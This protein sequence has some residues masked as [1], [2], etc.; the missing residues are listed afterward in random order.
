MAVQHPVDDSTGSTS[1]RRRLW[2][3]FG[4]GVLVLLVVIVLVANAWASQ[5]A[6]SDDGVSMPSATSPSPSRTASPTPAPTKSPTPAP[7]VPS[8]PDPAAGIGVPST[9][10][11]PPQV[12]APVPLADPAAAVPGV[13]FSISELESVAGEA[14]GPGEVAGP[15][16]RFAVTVRNDTAVSVS[17]TSTVVNFYYGGEQSPATELA[18]PGGVPLPDAVSAGG[19][20]RGVFIF[21]VPDDGRDRVQIAVDYSAGVPIVLFEGP[22]PK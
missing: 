2:W 18:A 20:A 3:I 21:N 15:S 8:A 7:P 6:D 16:L 11:A 17:L 14:R 10:L 22:A 5:R 1:R 12:Q 13:V 19:T 4:C 9:E